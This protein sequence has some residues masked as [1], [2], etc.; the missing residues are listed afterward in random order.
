MLTLQTGHV[1]HPIDVRMS[2]DGKR[3][4]TYGG[5]EVILWDAETGNQ[6]LT[7]RPATS[8]NSFA[9]SRDG[10]WVACG[11]DDEHKIYVWDTTTGK[12]ER[13]ITDCP[14]SINALDLNEDGSRLVV[15]CDD[16]HLVV[17]NRDGEKIAELKAPDNDY[18]TVALSGDG[19]IAACRSH[20]EKVHVW[21]VDDK[22][23][24]HTLQGHSEEV[25]SIAVDR[26]GERI[27]TGGEDNLVIVWNG[28]TGEEVQSFDGHEHDVKHV[29]IT[30]DGKTAL[31]TS[32]DFTTRIWDVAKGTE[33][34]SFEK[35]ET[36]IL[37]A[38]FDDRA[39]K[40][41][42]LDDD[43]RLVVWDVA[44]KRIATDRKNH[45]LGL[46]N[47][48]VGDRGRRL[49]V[50]GDDGFVMAWDLQ[51]GKPSRRVTEGNSSIYG[52]AVARNTP[53]MIHSTARESIVV[54]DGDDDRALERDDLSL[55]AIAIDAEGKHAVSGG[56]DHAVIFWDVEAGDARFV[57]SGH[58]ADVMGAALSADGKRAITTSRDQSICSWNTA[59][60]ERMFTLKGHNES[61]NGAAINA[62]GTRTA[63]GGDNGV[64][65]VW[66]LDTGKPI[67][68]MRG[69][70]GA[71]YGVAMSDDGRVVLSGGVDDRAYVW[72][73]VSGKKRFTLPHSDTIYGVALDDEGRLGFTTSGDGV[74]RCWN[75]ATGDLVCRMIA[76][77]EGDDW[78][79]VAPDGRY[80]GSEAGMKLVTFRVPDTDRFAPRSEYHA[81]CHTPG[82]LAKLLAAERRD[83]ASN[84]APSK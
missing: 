19:K 22:K 48:S 50:V 4:A 6:N 58:T 29:S 13:I 40:I 46:K 2:A 17:W 5:N 49:L 42:A 38:A 52:A 72:D 37:S 47:I 55:Y 62:D 65:I 68:K 73:A 74:V 25:S 24:L 81:Q 82:L 41:A 11:T 3:Y 28:K 59:V 15:A 21:S 26:T 20:D 39:R 36:V 27:V 34:A 18:E 30:P 8:P 12:L 10:R 61:A 78:L 43:G 60:G 70:D 80:D 75:T 67:H 1:G 16:Q 7:L 35:Y 57:L 53:R 56:P 45:L 77:T 64:V 79:V 76:T 32:A 83:A 63:T 66:N 23:L 84:V 69:H 54:W 44:E 33:L 9:M 14:E 71:A 51:N 31:S